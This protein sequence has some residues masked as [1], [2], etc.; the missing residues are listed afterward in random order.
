[1]NADV[2][3]CIFSSQCTSDKCDYSCVKNTMSELLLEKSEISFRSDCYKIPSQVSERYLQLANIYDGKLVTLE[4]KNPQFVAEGLTYSYICKLCE[5]HGSKITVY[6][7]KYSKYLQAIKDSWTS[8][9]SPQ[10]KEQ[11][12]FCNTSKVLIISS[13]DFVMYSD[14]ECQTLLNLFQ[15]R[16]KPGL[17]TFIVLSKISS[18][19]SK[20]NSPFYEMLK[21]QLEG[22]VYH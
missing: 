13:L 16:S 21:S 3:N 15:D 6:H 11:Q 10:L 12:A 9:I 22:G 7:M 5:G 1:M 8:G 18:L 20:N 4:V 14:F 17:C 19:V 2:R